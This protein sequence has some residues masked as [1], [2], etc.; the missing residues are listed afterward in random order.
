MISIFTTLGLA[1]GPGAHGAGA[2]PKGLGPVNSGLRPLLRI[3]NRG[4]APIKGY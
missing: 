3:V 2:G 1:Q 4:E